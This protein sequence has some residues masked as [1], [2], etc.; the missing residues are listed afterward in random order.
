[1]QVKRKD[2]V[3]IARLFKGEEFLES[4]QSLCT[5]E[6]I[7]SGRIQAIGAVQHATLGYF[8]PKKK[9]YIHFDCGGEVVSCMGTISTRKDTSEIIIHAH[10]VIAN[11]KGSC[12][13]GHVVQAEPSV[14][15]EVIIEEGPV[16]YR[17]LDSETGLYLLDV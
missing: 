7:S 17:S 16:L 9:K 13:G 6:S 14:T 4:I 15:L 8:D 10:A 12:K 5:E 2:T 11:Q 3:I 1:M